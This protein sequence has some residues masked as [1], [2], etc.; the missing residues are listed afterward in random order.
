MAG[1][2]QHLAVL[3]DLREAFKATRRPFLVEIHQDVV[4][5]KRQSLMAA[6][7]RLH[8]REAHGQIQLLGGSPAQ[9]GGIQLKSVMA[10]HDQPPFAERRKHTHIPAA[11]DDGH[12]VRRLPKHLRLS[13]PLI[14][15][16][17]LTR[18]LAIA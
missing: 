13:L 4:E 11:G 1:E 7:M 10:L 18:P 16:V 8:Q 2:H 14:D 5:H 3:A 15:R 17:R 9:A 12:M 6:V